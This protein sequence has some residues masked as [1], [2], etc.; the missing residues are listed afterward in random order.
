MATCIVYLSGGFG[1]QLHQLSVALGIAKSSPVKISLALLADSSRTPEIL[2]MI[3]ISGMNYDSHFCS[4]GLKN[5]ATPLVDVKPAS[6]P[7]CILSYPEHASW[8]LHVSDPLNFQEVLTISLE[9]NYTIQLIDELVVH[10]RLGDYLWPRAL[11]RF[12][13]LKKS[14]YE[15]C[16]TLLPQAYPV[17]ALTDDPSAL[18]KIYGST[19]SNRLIEIASSINVQEDFVRMI[20]AKY[21]VSGNSS[22]SLWAL[23]YRSHQDSV[24]YPGSISIG[25]NHVYRKVNKE[26][27][28]SNGSVIPDFFNPIAFILCHP[29]ALSRRLKWKGKYW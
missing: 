21:F 13:V 5:E 1:N 2:E 17:V 15:K 29:F 27:I 28:T 25:P 10:F 8:L 9:K 11:T 3:S 12:G 19:L 20:N 7:C 14:Y 23:W 24:Q 18:K 26:M 6:P 22:L 16:L 4:C